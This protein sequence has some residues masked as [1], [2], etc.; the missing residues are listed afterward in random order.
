MSRYQ[1]ENMV[2]EKSQ[3]SEGRPWSLENSKPLEEEKWMIRK[4]R[5]NS[6]SER[7]CD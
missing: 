6:M 2:Q 5:H 1:R 7:V 4:A 3:T